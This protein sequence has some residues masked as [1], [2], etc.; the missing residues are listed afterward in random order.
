[1][2]SD[3]QLTSVAEWLNHCALLVAHRVRQAEAPLCWVIDITTQGPM[4]R[5]GGK[6]LH[7]RIQVVSSLPET[8]G[9][10]ST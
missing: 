5:W 3:D 10:N 6:E 7:V 8:S 4:D 2:I 1:M 9:H